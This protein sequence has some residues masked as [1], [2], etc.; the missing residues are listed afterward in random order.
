MTEQF[1]PCGTTGQYGIGQA[2]DTFILSERN[3]RGEPTDDI[4]M[5]Y[6]AFDLATGEQ[7]TQTYG[8]AKAVESDVRGREQAQ[9]QRPTSTNRRFGRRSHPLGTAIEAGD[10]YTIYSDDL[11]GRGRVQIW[12]D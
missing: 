2:P 5:G 7:I 11:S 12:D 9:A 4:P 6:A 3:F 8:T 10:G 1:T